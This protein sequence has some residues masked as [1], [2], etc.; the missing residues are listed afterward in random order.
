MEFAGTCVGSGLWGW[1][2][3]GGHYW[4]R[5][6]FSDLVPEH[7]QLLIGVV[8]VGEVGTGRGGVEGHRRLSHQRQLRRSLWYGRDVHTVPVLAL[9][10]KASSANTKALNEPEETILLRSE[11]D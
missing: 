9:A 1:L 8:F 4:V 2:H 5:G 7:C 10:S 11:P 6:D 3:G